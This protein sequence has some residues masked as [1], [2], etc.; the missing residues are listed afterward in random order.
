MSLFVKVTDLFVQHVVKVTD[1]F[2]KHARNFNKKGHVL[3]VFYIP[4]NLGLRSLA[5]LFVK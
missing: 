2:V 5:Y 1:L 4:Q 3:H